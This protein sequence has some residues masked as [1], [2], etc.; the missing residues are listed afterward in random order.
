MLYLFISLWLKCITASAS[1][2]PSRIKIP[3]GAHFGYCIG[4]QC[5]WCCIPDCFSA[6]HHRFTEHV[7][8]DKL[9]NLVLYFSPCLHHLNPPCMDYSTRHLPSRARHRHCAYSI[10]ERKIHW[11]AMVHHIS[12]IIHHC[13]M[14]CEPPA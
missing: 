11:C 8:A 14:V 5:R 6:K 7:S 1:Q 9:G 3:E 12:H 4:L 2:S 13:F 10:S